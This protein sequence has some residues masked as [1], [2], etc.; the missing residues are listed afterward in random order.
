MKK[1]VFLFLAVCAMCVAF[2]CSGGKEK[3]KDFTRPLQGDFV[4][5]GHPD[6]NNVMQYGLN[7]KD[8]IVLYAI[9]DTIYWDKDLNG[10]VAK[11]STETS[12]VNTE[13][14]DLCPGGEAYDSITLM[15]DYYR[16]VGK[17]NIAYYDTTNGRAWG[18]FD[19]IVIADNFFFLKEGENWGLYLKDGTIILDRKYSNIY[20]VNYKSEK[21]FNV[22][23]HSQNE[24]FMLNA[25]GA[26]YNI[27]SAMLE[28]KVKA[29]KISE[30]V[31]KLKAG[32]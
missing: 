24:W 23:C 31:G 26:Y 6:E 4:L 25:E 22:V 19:S 20:V 27:P 17:D 8:D 32:F 7:L 30:S 13:G 2:S 9:F 10:F 11:S 21:D 28:K 16:F 15:G 3:S 18:P 5:V 1:I 12:L 29:L 14:E